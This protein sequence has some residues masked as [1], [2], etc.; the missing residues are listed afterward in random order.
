M[1]QS[2]YI[3]IGKRIKGA[4][5]PNG[6]GQ[7]MSNAGKENYIFYQF[8]KQAE[9]ER[10]TN[11]GAFLLTEKESAL[12][13]KAAECINR[14]LAPY[15]KILE[16]V[17]LKVDTM[18]VIVN[19]T[20]TSFADNK[21]NIKKLRSIRDKY[22]SAYYWS[23]APEIIKKED[24]NG[25]LI[26]AATLNY[27]V[28]VSTEEKTKD[29]ILDN[30]HAF[31]K[32]ETMQAR[33]QA[34]GLD[35]ICLY[36]S[37]YELNTIDTLSLIF[38]V[39]DAGATAETIQ[40]APVIESAFYRL[41]N[42][43]ALRALN[44][45]AEAKK[46][47]LR[48]GR[49]EQGQQIS[50]ADY[51]SSAG[52]DISFTDFSPYAAGGFITVGDPNTDKLL[53]QAQILTAN[54]GAQKLE[55]TI[56]DF[57]EFRGLKDNKAAIETAKTAC[58]RLRRAGS[59]IAI[60]DPIASLTGGWN[61]V[62]KAFVAQTGNKGKNKIVIEWTNDIYNHITANIKAGQQIEQIDKSIFTIPDKQAPA[63]NIACKFS[64]HLRINAGRVNDHRLSVNTL[65]D[66][67]PTWPLYTEEYK[68]IPEKDKCNYIK[69][70]SQ[71]P[72]RII[73][74]FIETLEYL[75]NEKKIFRSYKFLGKNG[76]PLTDAKLKEARKDY[77]TFINL[78]VEVEFNNEPDYTNL[79]EQKSKRQ[80]IAAQ[81]NTKKNQRKKAK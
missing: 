58:N 28:T 10:K 35:N 13:S 21:I 23:I 20:I 16:D 31:F 26:T 67:V 80:E 52:V 18:H 57:M 68:S 63:Y 53:Q 17:L 56:K 9:Q 50:I 30:N 77:K 40:T 8:E 33:A 54:T 79:K 7:T 19:D 55:I 78:I 43:K 48:K 47:K 46:P 2:N 1:L 27:K 61:Y 3:I 24:K 6:G 25:L 41:V 71:A 38:S 5:D 11:P 70:P 74:P 32:A 65:I 62:Q 12:I 73:K 42:S 51:L 64:S 36:V 29:I 44:I 76:K 39:Y 75:T 66:C 49:N 59:E 14:V 69:Y 81:A 37:R 45:G 60:S 15:S 72:D 22:I 34:L 4:A